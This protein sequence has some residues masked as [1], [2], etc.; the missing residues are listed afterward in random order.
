MYHNEHETRSEFTDMIT[1]TAPVP[2]PAGALL[3]GVSDTDGR[4]HIVA[5]DSATHALDLSADPRVV[6]AV[7]L[8]E[9]TVG[10]APMWG[11]Y[12]REA[13]H[14]YGRPCHDCLW[15]LALHRGTV[16]DELG[17]ARPDDVDAAAIGAAGVDPHL[18]PNLLSTI[19]GDPA[20]MRS[21]HPLGPTH[22]TQLLALASR[23][24][25]AVSVCEECLDFGIHNAHD[26]TSICPAQS[27]FCPACTPAA[28]QWAGEWEGTLLSEC[29]VEAPCSVLT[30]LAAHYKLDTHL[31]HHRSG[32]VDE[33]QRD[34]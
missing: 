8:C 31:G 25:P 9:R 10:L 1:D 26:D 32:G 30:T 18:G 29:L 22:Q 12:D 34:Q 14:R 4:H 16:A 6:H 20:L 7:A 13:A 23:H 28:G 21:H 24:L 15:I 17:A 2:L 27:V 11:A 3:F 5:R 33:R 19:V